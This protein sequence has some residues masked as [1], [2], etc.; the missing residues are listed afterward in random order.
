MLIARRDHDA[1]RPTW[2]CRVCGQTWPCA[3][4]KVD[5]VEQFERGRTMLILFMGSCMVEAIDDLKSAGGPPADLY[6]RFLGW[7]RSATGP[8]KSG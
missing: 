8:D 5:L 3:T 4:A 1:E 6:D 7:A 2:D